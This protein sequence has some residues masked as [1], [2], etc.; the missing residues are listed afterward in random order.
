MV[1]ELA[2]E[3]VVPEPVAREQEPVARYHPRPL[4]TAPERPLQLDEV[5]DPAQR[6]SAAA[7]AKA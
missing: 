1:P 2:R 5:V 3:E 7:L 6:G 4:L